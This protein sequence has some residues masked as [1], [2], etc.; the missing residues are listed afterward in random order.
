MTHQYTKTIRNKLD[1]VGKSR[2]YLTDLN[3]L[4]KTGQALFCLAEKH[5]KNS[6]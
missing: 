5:E 1:D 4:K 2:I 6:I 3:N